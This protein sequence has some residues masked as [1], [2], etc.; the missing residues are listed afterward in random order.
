MFADSII[1]NMLVM[2]LVINIKIQ[3]TCPTSGQGNDGTLSGFA[4]SSGC[5]LESGGEVYKTPMLGPHPIS[6]T[7]R[8]LESG[9]KFGYFFKGS[10]EI[11]MCSQS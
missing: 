1:I 6:M 2:L 8:L 5:T 9:L 10:Q 7:S 3:C 11:P 4:G